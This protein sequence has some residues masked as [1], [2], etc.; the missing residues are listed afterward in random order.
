MDQ[1]QEEQNGNAVVRLTRRADDGS[2]EEI[3]IH[4]SSVCLVR[5][6][7]YRRPRPARYRFRFE[8]EVP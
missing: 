2:V 5:R 7:V 4:A 6:R 8:E 3:V 1:P